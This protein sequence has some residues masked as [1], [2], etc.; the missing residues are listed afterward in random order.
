MTERLHI[1]THKGLFELARHNSVWDIADVQ[2]LGDPVSAVLA[3]AD[4]IVYA[5]LDLGHLEPSYG[6]ATTPE[7]GA[8]CPCR[9]S[10]PSPRMPVTIPIP[11]LSARSGHSN[12]AG[13]R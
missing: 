8:S 5:A 2:F 12:R 13:F 11:G 6:A 10:R 9:H 7:T 3:V 1:G 4:G